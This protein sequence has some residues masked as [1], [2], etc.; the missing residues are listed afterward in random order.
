MN[1][2]CGQDDSDEDIMDLTD[3]PVKAPPP[4]PKRQAPHVVAAAAKKAKTEGLAQG[5]GEST[6]D[7][8]APIAPVAAIASARAAHPA[9]VNAV[10]DHKAPI[11]PVAAPA[12]V[13]SVPPPATSPFAGAQAALRTAMSAAAGAAGSAVSAGLNVALAAA[14]A[15]AGAGNS[16]IPP[17]S[18]SIPAAGVPPLQPGAPPG[19]FNARLPALSYCGTKIQVLAPDGQMVLITVP[20][21]PGGYWA[22]DS[23]IQ[24]P[25]PKAKVSAQEKL[26]EALDSDVG[27]T[28]TNSD[29]QTFATYVP[30]SFTLSCFWPHP[31]EIFE[32]SSMSCLPPP[33][34]TYQLNICSQTILRG[35]LTNAQLEAISLSCSQHELRLPGTGA[36]AAFFLGDGPGVGKGRQAAGIIFENFLRGRKKGLWFSASPDLVADARRD[37]NDIGAECVSCWN[38]KD[39]SISDKLDDT[40]KWDED[41][42]ADG[43]LFCTYTLLTSDR[44]VG[45]RI[46]Q[47]VE[48]CGGENFDGPLILDECH[49][50]K[51][52]G[53]GI[54]PA[55]GGRGRR[56]R[57]K[58]DDDDDDKKGWGQS[59]ATKT[60]TFVA[61]LQERLPLARIVYVSATGASEPKHFMQLSR[62]GLW[63]PNCSFRDADDFVQ[64]IKKG[65]VGAMELVAMH[66]KASGQYISRSLSFSSATFE[67]INVEI[68]PAFKRK[69]DGACQLWNDFI[70]AINDERVLAKKPKFFMGIL[71]GAHQRFFA[72]MI[73]A[74]KV[75]V[76]VKQV[77]KSLKEKKCCVIGLQSTGEASS[78]DAKE[79]SAEEAAVGDLEEINSTAASNFTR[80]VDACKGFL[81]EPLR[82]SFLK[83]C[84]DL[85][86]PANP[87]DEIIHRLGGPNKVAEMTGRR[88]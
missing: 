10:I 49:K 76:V 68:E 22:Y 56:G 75:D 41:R 80:L 78:E 50:A 36:R 21:T 39:Y 32:T 26:D 79:K 59:K 2:P 77:Q 53:S 43:V 58:D 33:K 47:I 64:S 13:G 67:L 65:G 66:M 38:L 70:A 57:R 87:L 12:S 4:V 61:D 82:K 34:T 19:F 15:A 3:S 63:G 52:M 23:I 11:A 5:G 18:V 44:E 35:L 45:K 20:T 83:R 55:G 6:G 54:A 30:T 85:K 46:D 40:N 27:L 9:S 88:V 42:L 51:N 71:W 29:E 31:D 37:L 81:D 28:H 16:S 24:V 1:V 25:L 74:A 48:W 86:L 60:A 8:K 69:Y 14:A 62:L 73:M 84:A 17:A 7:H 72:H